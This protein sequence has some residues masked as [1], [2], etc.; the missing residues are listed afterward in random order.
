M[1]H[2]DQAYCVPGRSIADNLFLIRDVMELAN[3]VPTDLGLISLD[4]EKA[5][6]R[7]DHGYLFNTLTNFSFGEHFMKSVKLLYT[8][9]SCV[10]KVKKVN[11]LSIH[12]LPSITVSAYADAV[13]V[14]VR[15]G[16]DIRELEECL[17][18]YSAAS[19]VKVDWGKSGALLCVPW[20]DTEPPQLPGGLGWSTVDLLDTATVRHSPNVSPITCDAC[21]WKMAGH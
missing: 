18:T 10:V 1:V 15:N 13:S 20:R 19:S 3:R 7:V 8:G 12:G 14:F 4:Q 6:D 11:G 5:F 21:G 16:T 2:R 9:A 17:H